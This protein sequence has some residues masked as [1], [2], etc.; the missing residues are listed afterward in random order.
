MNTQ[1]A[2]YCQETIHHLG[3]HTHVVAYGSLGLQEI[4]YDDLD[5]FHVMFPWIV[6]FSAIAF[7]LD[8]TINGLN[9]QI[10]PAW[11]CG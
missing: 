5:V 7:R 10:E 4:F 9:A 3:V 1:N 6:A 2:G 8:G 11:R